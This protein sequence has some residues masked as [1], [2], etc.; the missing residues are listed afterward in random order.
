MLHNP[1]KSSF[2]PRDLGECLLCVLLFEDKMA[3]TRAFG[4]TKP[5]RAEFIDEPVA[6]PR[7]YDL[8]NRKGLLR[9]AGGGPLS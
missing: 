8:L 4:I 5:H 7:K 3:G 1:T 9:G 2:L 6:Q